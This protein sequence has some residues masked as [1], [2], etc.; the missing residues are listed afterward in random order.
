M[1]EI[2]MRHKNRQTHARKLNS[3]ASKLISIR[4]G[5]MQKGGLGG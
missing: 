3:N 4:Q 5:C 2:K 1:A